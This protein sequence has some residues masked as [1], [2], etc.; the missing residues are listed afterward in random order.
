MAQD[1]NPRD[2][3]YNRIKNEYDSATCW[4]FHLGSN[5]LTEFV[6]E[7]TDSSLNSL[8]DRI[9]T[10]NDLARNTGAHTRSEEVS[11]LYHGDLKFDSNDTLNGADAQ[12]YT[13]LALAEDYLKAG[14][15]T[16][17]IEFF[18]IRAV[19]TSCSGELNYKN[20][21]FMQK[22]DKPGFNTRRVISHAT[23]NN[24][25][26]DALF[27]AM[28][29]NIDFKDINGVNTNYGFEE[30]MH[31]ARDIG[32]KNPKEI[33]E[34]LMYLTEIRW[35]RERIEPDPEKPL[36]IKERGFLH[37]SDIAGHEYEFKIRIYHSAKRCGLPT[38]GVL[39]TLEAGL[40]KAK[41][42]AQYPGSGKITDQFRLT[43]L[44]QLKAD[45]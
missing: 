25:Y 29:F 15:P 21:T 6:Q 26:T 17:Q 24:F 23:D 5:K 45:Q 39:E 10:I 33:V 18:Y 20:E 40:E 35:A 30:M 22:R 14:Q 9:V 36:H 12:G 3:L 43:L 1:N 27:E 28:F 16:E 13:F 34:N 11:F 38:E 8:T 4:P 41:S 44:K 32:K 31:Y 19:D 7:Q 37:H 42:S 2:A